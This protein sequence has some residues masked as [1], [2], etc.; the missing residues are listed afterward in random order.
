MVI[1]PKTLVDKKEALIG[2]FLYYIVV[3]P[4]IRL[5]LKFVYFKVKDGVVI[6]KVRIRIKKVKRFFR[7]KSFLLFFEESRS[8][9][10]LV[11]MVSLLFPPVKSFY[12]VMIQ[13]ITGI[14]FHFGFFWY[15]LMLP[16]FPSFLSFYTKLVAGTKMQL[17]MIKLTHHVSDGCDIDNGLLFLYDFLA[18]LLSIFEVVMFVVYITLIILSINLLG[19]QKQGFALILASCQ[20]LV[21][22][23]YSQKINFRF[24]PFLT[25]LQKWYKSLIIARYQLEKIK[26][27]RASNNF[28]RICLISSWLITAMMT[29]TLI[30]SA[31]RPYHY[32]LN[33][34]I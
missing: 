14:A 22:K 9:I 21:D 25:E 8:F 5:C 10:S 28:S 11:I 29:A 33:K 31:F 30:N 2:Y 7:K 19:G 23:I 27:S 1:K 16:F 4:G 6:K 12:N 32:K 20:Q 3:R 17:L 24:L 34:F 15:N 13:T 26:W 18:I